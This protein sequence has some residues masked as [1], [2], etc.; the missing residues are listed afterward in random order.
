MVLSTLLG[1]H[2]PTLPV[3]ALIAV[4]ALFA[5]TEGTVRV[6]VSRMAGEGDL[7]KEGDGYRLSPRLIERQR[8]Q[9]EARTPP[10]RPWKGDW[11]MAVVTPGRR[12][13]PDRLSLRDAMVAARMAEAREGVWLRPANLARGVPPVV[14]QQCRLFSCR[15]EEDPAALASALWGLDAWGAK[16]VTLMAVME[17][18][19]DPAPRFTV[20]AAIMRHLLDDP[21]LPEQLLPPGWP[22]RALREC[23]STYERELGTLLSAAL[24]VAAPT[25]R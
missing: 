7:A 11:E 13:A 9:D 17:S 15:P 19:D 3:R 22:G 1:T 12:Q 10:M 18:T 6:A 2:P 23:Y 8:R 25:G 5:I 16:A 24:P 20:S 21:L 14:E 4:G